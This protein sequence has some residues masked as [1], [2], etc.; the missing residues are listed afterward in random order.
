MKSYIYVLKAA[1]I[2]ATAVVVAAL[3]PGNTR[4][5]TS[6][7]GSRA[8]TNI[9]STGAGY[10][11]ILNLT[12]DCTLSVDSDNRSRFFIFRTDPV[13][14]AIE[15]GSPADGV[16]QTGDYITHVDGYGIRT[17]EGARR[18]AQVQPGQRMELG[19]WRDGKKSTV[20]LTASRVSWGDR[21]VLGTLAPVAP[22]P[23][24]S[25]VWEGPTPEPPEP[26]QPTIPAEPAIAPR[27]P[28]TPRAARAAGAMQVWSVTPAPEVVPARPATPS[29][30]P[31]PAAPAISEAWTVVVPAS[32]A[33]PSGWYGFSFRCNNCGWSSSGRSGETPVWES[34]DD[35]P[36]EL[37][38]VD[39]GGPAA[40][41]GLKA[42]DRITA[43]DGHSI[44]SF[45]GARRLGAVVPG[46]TVRLTVRR[47]QEVLVRSLTLGR[48]PEARARAMVGVT[49]STPRPGVR[50]ELR[51]SG[52][53]DDVAVEVYSASPST[54]ERVGD[55]LVITV[56]ASVIR[57]K[58]DAKK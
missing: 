35:T 58:A 33:S 53:I 25:I 23:G 44:N 1:R 50:R 10:L 16:L 41:A 21:R 36:P 22:R 31:R 5:Q 9:N 45:E 57:L 43:I 6:V 29:A 2:A 37:S 52:K 13:V 24:F 32:P 48:R 17:T 18:F 39:P 54:V 55:L 4:A 20:R 38:I 15:D 27:P 7:G 3:L 49:A 28:R 14:G 46:Q 42:G 12:C 26:A 56:G 8:T 40:R 34:N 47:G 19:I 51:Y 11:G 30:P